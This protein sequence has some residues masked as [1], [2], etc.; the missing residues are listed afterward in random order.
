MKNFTIE[1]LKNYFEKSALQLI[2][3]DYHTNAMCFQQVN[4]LSDFRKLAAFS[5]EHVVFLKAERF[6]QNDKLDEVFVDRI[7]NKFVLAD[8]RNRVKAAVLKD[9]K[10]YNYKVDK[11]LKSFKLFISNNVY[12]YSY[13]DKLCEINKET[14]VRYLI[15]KNLCKIIKKNNYKKFSSNTEIF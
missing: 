14:Y 7:L 6:S 15:Y 10:A 11:C 4:S 5:N 3:V 9:V 13:T 2:Q 8:S 1:E 12:Y